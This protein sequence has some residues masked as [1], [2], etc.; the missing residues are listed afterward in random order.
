MNFPLKRGSSLLS[1]HGLSFNQYCLV[2]AL[3]NAEYY[4]LH[5]QTE[6]SDGCLNHN[7]TAFI[8]IKDHDKTWNHISDDHFCSQ[9][10]GKYEVLWTI[11]NKQIKAEPQSL[12]IL[13]IN[14]VQVVKLNVLGK[15]WALGDKFH[16][17]R[18]CHYIGQILPP[19]LN[20]EDRPR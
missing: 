9:T 6:P 5:A 1:A 16:V 18:Q 7:L 19:I 8:A 11:N 2:W 13:V 3:K 12:P 4:V 20:S 15:T 17:H 10:W 14:R